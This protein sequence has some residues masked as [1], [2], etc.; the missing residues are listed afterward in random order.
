MFKYNCIYI[1]YLMYIYLCK[2]AYVHLN[3]HANAN[4]SECVRLSSKNY[5]IDLNF[6]Y[7]KCSSV[8]RTNSNT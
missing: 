5:K 1:D 7:K 8:G 2:F 6:C 4:A 3:M